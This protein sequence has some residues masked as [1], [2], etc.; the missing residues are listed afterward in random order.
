MY[1]QH[2]GR[3]KKW[4]INIC[5]VWGGGYGGWEVQNKS[6]FWKQNN[7]LQTQMQI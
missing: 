2:D 4:Q 1:D 6:R 5:F 3:L 7:K